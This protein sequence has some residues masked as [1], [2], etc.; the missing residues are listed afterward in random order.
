LDGDYYEIRVEGHL[1]T[2]GEQWSDGLRV[3]HEDS[4]ATLLGG[5]V[6]QAGLHGVLMRIRDL[7]LRLVSVNR[8]AVG[9]RDDR[10]SGEQRCKQVDQPP[11]T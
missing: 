4:G 11:G 2:S 3:H 9:S 1:G 7:G 8:L 5:T 10:A 6:D